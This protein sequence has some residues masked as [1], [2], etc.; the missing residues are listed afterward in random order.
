MGNLLYIILGSM[1]FWKQGLQ[2]ERTT[3]IAKEAGFSGLSR[4][5][6]DSYTN[7]TMRGL[8]ESWTMGESSIF[9]PKKFNKIEIVANFLTIIEKNSKS[10]FSLI[11]R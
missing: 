9:S 10:T 8:G 1:N 5:W 11:Y 3:L 4:P 2:D 7:P 6:W